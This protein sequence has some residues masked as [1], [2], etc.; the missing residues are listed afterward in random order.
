MKAVLEFELDNPD[1]KMAHLRCVKSLDMALFIWDVSQ[2]LHKELK[3][4]EL[5][6][7]LSDLFEN[8]N[9]VINELI[10]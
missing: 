8:Y 2:L 10:N 7:K 1:D 6:R 3:P 4:D 5:N 9:I